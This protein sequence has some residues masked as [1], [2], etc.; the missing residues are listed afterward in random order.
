MRLAHKSSKGGKGPTFRYVPYTRQQKSTT[1]TTNTS[2]ATTVSPDSVQIPDNRETVSIA[3]KAVPQ[4]TPLVQ[5][6]LCCF[7]NPNVTG[8][9]NRYSLPCVCVY[10]YICLRYGLYFRFIY[11]FCCSV[12]NVNSA[13]IRQLIRSGDLDKLE[14]LVLEGQGK[15][16]IGEYSADYKIRSFL[17]TVPTLMVSSFCYPS[18][19]AQL[20]EELQMQ[21][22]IFWFF[23][24]S[25][26]II[27]SSEVLFVIYNVPR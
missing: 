6:R 24:M 23:I 25:L 20:I 8:I 12:L 3:F 9:Y 19:I 4:N 2:T 15:K 11:S 21:A 5:F 13:H 10:I 16:L 26:N 22:V 1:T 7:T 17:K 18:N 14:Q 27:G